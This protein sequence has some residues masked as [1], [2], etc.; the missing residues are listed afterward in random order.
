MSNAKPPAHCAGV[1]PV[2]KL[3][4]EDGDAQIVDDFVAQ[5]TAIAF[6]YNCVTYGVMMATP[7]DLED[8][9]VGFS[10][11]EGIVASADELLDIE[12]AHSDQGIVLSMIIPADRLSALKE[13]RR[14]M[15][16]N[17]GCGVCG[18]ESI[19]HVFK[20]VHSVEL[21]HLEL[22]HQAIQFAIE[23]LHSQQTMNQKTGAQHAA[24]WSD[25]EGHLLRVREDVGRH[26]AL[27]KLIGA[28]TRDGVSPTSGFLVVSSR[29][30]Y[31]MVQKTAQFGAPVLAAVS[32]VTALAIE[33]ATQA[34]IT[35]VG[36]SRNGR[37]SIYTEADRVT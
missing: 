6:E 29:A 10:L 4:W 7:T 14:T 15:I 33:L 24:A 22:R 13:R 21:R 8:F 35:L 27:D 25:L 3:Q 31:E 23:S 37:H 2:S 28:L 11:S 17:S 30:S 18:S 9:A 1:Q 34:K 20:A 5:E 19:E 36:F 26:N 32:G 16:G 12:I